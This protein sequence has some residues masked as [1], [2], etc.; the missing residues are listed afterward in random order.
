MSTKTKDNRSVRAVALASVLAL[1]LCTPMAAFA[2]E[3]G[4]ETD[5]AAATETLSSAVTGTIKATTLCV[6]VPT[7]VSFYLD[8]GAEQG[9]TLSGTWP[10]DTKFGQYTNPSNLTITNHSAVDVYGYVP[11]VASSYVTLVDSTSGLAK[12]GGVSPLADGS[13]KSRIGVMVGICDTTES[14]SLETPGDWMTEGDNQTYYA[15]NKNGHGRLAAASDSQ[16]TVDNSRDEVK[17]EY[18][19]TIRGAVFQGGWSQNESFLVQPVFKIVTTDPA[20][21]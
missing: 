8:P 1:V 4:S 11:K 14:M 12:P 16:G 6:T 7:K 9:T 21:A 20:G 10:T 13:N 15:F 5:D 18:T 3:V 2:V 19:M 17:G